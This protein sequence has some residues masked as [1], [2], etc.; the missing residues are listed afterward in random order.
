MNYNRSVTADNDNNSVCTKL[1][2][3]V[4]AS[5]SPVK[6]VYPISSVIQSN[7]SSTSSLV[8]NNST[9]KQKSST[10]T[11]I[12]RKL[13]A[14]TLLSDASHKQVTDAPIENIACNIPVQ[15]SASFNSACTVPLS[16][17]KTIQVKNSASFSNCSILAKVA[18]K[19]SV[20]AT[21]TT[22]PVLKITSNSVTNILKQQMTNVSSG[23]ANSMTNTYKSNITE[24]L[25]NAGNNNRIQPMTNKS[26]SGGSL[27]SSTGQ[28]PSSSLTSLSSGASS[29]MNGPAGG[30]PLSLNQSISTTA[31][32][33]A[34]LK[35]NSTCDYY[36]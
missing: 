4:I 7:Y 5:F 2:D 9:T 15:R 1:T 10:V 30:H 36:V 6:D 3:N 25:A 31:L 34:Q 26:A 32:S 21:L 35:N 17:S 16:I 18:K 12:G 8:S 23:S 33:L 20:L 11:I 28:L 19:S 24:T 14:V 22:N 13:D 29:V 27:S